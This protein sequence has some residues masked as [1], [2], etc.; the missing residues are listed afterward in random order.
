MKKKVIIITI[1]IVLILISCLVIFWHRNNSNNNDFYLKYEYQD[2]WGGEIKQ[3][4]EIN[5]S[6]YNFSLLINN[7]YELENIDEKNNGTLT[8]E[9]QNNITKLIKADSNNWKKQNKK[10]KEFV[11]NATDMPY[12]HL[13]IKNNGVTF[14]LDYL[15]LSVKSVL[16]RA[17]EK[18]VY[19]DIEKAYNNSNH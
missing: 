4:V 8:E 16:E 5:N 9:Q 2:H 12:E 1:L 13:I 15:P 18:S 11:D 19:D 3:V 7:H 10:I 17:L 14:E 6:E